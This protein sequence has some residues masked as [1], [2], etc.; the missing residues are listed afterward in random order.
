MTDYCDQCASLRVLPKVL[1]EDT[2]TP[3]KCFGSNF[4][5]D[6]LERESQKI[7]ILR[8]GVTQ[9]TRAT[10]IDDQKKDTLRQALL[11]LLLDLLP[12][13]GTEVRLDAATAFHS[14]EIESLT[15]DT[16]LSKLGV[17]LVIGRTLNKNKNPIAENAVKEIQ[18]EILRYK[19]SPGQISSVDL[20]IILRNINSRVRSNGLSS[21]EMMLRRDILSNEPIDTNDAEVISHKAKARTKS[22]IASQKHKAKS[23]KSTLDQSFNIGDLV[24]L[25]EGSSKIKPRESFIVDSLTQ[26]PDKFILI[27]KLSQTLRPKLYKALPQELIHLPA[28]T[29]PKE[30]G[31]KRKAA[32]EANVKIKNCLRSITSPKKRI[33]KHGWIEQDQPEDIDIFVTLPYQLSPTLDPVSE[34]SHSRSSSL[35]SNNSIDDAA[36]LSWD[37]TPAQ[38]N[39][40]SSPDPPP[41]VHAP[42][43]I[44]TSTPFPSSRDE[45]IRPF[46]RTRLFASTDPSLTRTP[47]FRLPD[48]DQAFLASP[49]PPNSQDHPHPP[50]KRSRI[51]AP[52]FPASV[53]L[54]SVSD[55]SYVL[56][57]RSM[58]RT[59]RPQLLWCL[60]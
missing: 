26:C 40:S 3:P 51:P 37:D 5:A 48:S 42:A 2:S 35:A 13:T 29:P 56:P 59:S 24:M 58:R 30:P 49:Q 31:T 19:Q 38:Y 8:E 18:K 36:D 21:K 1:I 41:F 32:H 4:A 16:L 9:F 20:A 53:N 55:L 7:L 39:L 46:T 60:K 12:D 14:L 50:R 33:F 23:R 6:V 17:R 25:R 10:I 34:Q 52:I 43:T 11:S 22:S 57:R 27:R 54:D 44:P 47:A 45:Q 28:A 15:S